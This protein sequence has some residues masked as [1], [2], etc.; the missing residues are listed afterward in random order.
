M[1]AATLLQAASVAVLAL[2]SMGAKAARSGEICAPFHYPLQR[3]S[4]RLRSAALRQTK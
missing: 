2:G 1:R 4:I 3:P